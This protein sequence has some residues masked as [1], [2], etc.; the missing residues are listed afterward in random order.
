MPPSTAG[1]AGEAD[2][3]QPCHEEGRPQQDSAAELR[4]DLRAARVGD[5][6]GADQVLGADREHEG[7]VL[8]GGACSHEGLER[9]PHHKREIHSQRQA[10][11]CRQGRLEEPNAHTR[12]TEL[13]RVIVYLRAEPTVLGT[14]GDTDPQPTPLDARTKHQAG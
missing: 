3:E 11:G 9:G 4:G 8:H 10:E 5:R 1:E 7:R 12:Y 13:W 14:G 2:S 6:P